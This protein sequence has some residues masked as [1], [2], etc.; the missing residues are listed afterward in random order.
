[1]S[2]QKNNQTKPIFFARILLVCFL[3]VTMI[4]PQMPSSF[5]TMHAFAEA[6]EEEVAESNED[7]SET[8]D[9]EGTLSFES[10]GEVALT[11]DEE[12]SDLDNAEAKNA[13]LA[14]ED[15]EEAEIIAFGDILHPT[16]AYQVSGEETTYGAKI[17]W[18]DNNRADRPT[19][20]FE[21]Y[22]RVVK[23]GVDDYMPLTKKVLTD[24]GLTDEEADAILTTPPTSSTGVNPAVYT[25]SG[26]PK[27]LNKYEIEEPLGEPVDNATIEYSFDIV[28]E[29]ASETPTEV[30]K[31][32]IIDPEEIDPS[33]GN[34]V[35]E[36]TQK[37]TATFTIDWKDG[38]GKYDTRPTT[39]DILDS[40]TLSNLVNNTLTPEGTL[41]ALIAA[42]KAEVEIVPS[43]DS[44][45]IKVS[46]LPL[47]KKDGS[48]IEYAVQEKDS[49]G[50]DR[51]STRLN[52]SH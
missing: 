41:S 34:T 32:Y 2:N 18:N 30:A 28:K 45:V 22:Y 21:L 8:I 24:W 35:V 7:K 50:T 25:F 14:K 11:E 16:H 31:Q 51:K 23:F 17:Q 12:I 27:S 15:D 38:S 37:T 29:D 39:D 1:M 19:P 48:K 44:W 6:T 33:K 46:E 5:M 36:L 47:Y 52:S 40:L 49:A 26:L 42:G 4:V 9:F 13:A 3:V 43:G 10:E 20:Q